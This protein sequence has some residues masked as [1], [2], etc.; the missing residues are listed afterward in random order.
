MKSFHAKLALAAIGIA[1]VA[2]PALAQRP[3]HWS[4]NQDPQYRDQVN[5]FSYGPNVGYPNPVTR[6][7]SAES[8]ES[9]AE[10]NLGY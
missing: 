8:R 3:H 2:T 9:G 4:Q 6:S 1:L 5:G 10:F 7:G